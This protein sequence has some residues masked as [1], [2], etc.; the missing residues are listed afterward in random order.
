MTVDHLFRRAGVR[1]PEALALADP[2]NRAA[3]MDGAPR[4][5]TFV[6]AD[7][8]IAA[9]AAKLRGLNLPADAVVGLQLPNTVE[10]VV[11]LLGTLRA[12]MVAAPLPLLWRRREIVTALGRASAK[13]I[14][15]VARA[16]AHAPAESAMQAAV[17]LFPIRYVC[18]F[19]E[20]VPDGVVP[21]DDVFTA[22][23]VAVPAARADRAAAITFEMDRDGAVPVVHTHA[24]LIAAGEAV[25]R[26]AGIAAEADIL[27]TIP[28]A[29]FAGIAVTLLPWLLAGGALHLHHGFDAEA[30]AAQSAALNGGTVVLPGPA[31]APLAEAGHIGTSAAAV[32]ALWRA[33]ERIAAAPAWQSETA[34]VDIAAATETGLLARRRGDGDMPAPAASRAGMV[35]V[36]GYR[37]GL[38]D[39]ER[40]VAEPDPAATIMARPDALTGERFAGSSAD[41]DALRAKLEAYGVNPLISGAFRE[42]K[43]A[44]G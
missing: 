13:A 38:R 5:L 20:A 21:L 39:L 31:V 3:I 44:A 4:A 37:F 2:A 19:G 29:G 14:V 36:G 24:D 17:D 7:R 32:L 23:A 30:F 25:F 11:A 6:Q 10:G 28:P 40:L 26:E 15:T 42:R 8:A 34:L 27:S 12:G 9:F 18:G 22:D 41:P 1:R 35:Q 43:T 33:P 16:G